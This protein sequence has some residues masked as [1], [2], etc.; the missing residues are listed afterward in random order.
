MS[1]MYEWVMSH[2]WMSHFTLHMQVHAIKGDILKNRL[3]QT[4]FE[5][6]HVY[7]WVKSRYT[8]RCMWWKVM[9]VYE[10]VMSHTYEWVMSR[11]W[12]GHVT[13][14]MQVHAI[15]GD[16]LW[17]IHET[18]PKRRCVAACCSVLQRVAVYCGVLPCI[19]VPCSEAITC[20]LSY[21]VAKTHRMP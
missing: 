14:H 21:S 17:A 10:C 12:M 18:H 1:H 6:C 8:C 3:R 9:C 5:S 4:Y 7:E 2:I 11:I 19:T 15:K 20:G 13:L 16:V